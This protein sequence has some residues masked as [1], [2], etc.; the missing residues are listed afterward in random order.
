[1]N[2]VTQA[3]KTAFEC[4]SEVDPRIATFIQDEL[5]SQRTSLKLIASENYSPLAVQMAMG[6][7]LTDKYAE[8]FPGHRFYS[9][10][11]N[12]DNIEALAVQH[13]KDLF[14]AEHAYVQ[15][16]S[17]ADAN[18]IAFWSILR[19]RVQLPMLERTGAD[20]MGMSREEWNELRRELN[21]QRMMAMNLDSGGH[22]THGFRRN[23]S[24]QLFDCHLYGVSPKTGLLDY[25]DIAKQME[26]VK[27]LIFLAGYSSYPRKIDFERLREICD[28]NGAIFMVD[29]AHF[30]GLVAGKVFDG[31]YNPVPY[32][33]VVTTT[34][35]KTLRGP[36]GGMILCKKEFAES[37]DKGCPMVMGG[38]MPHVM[39]SKAVAFAVAK[40]PEFR[41]YAQAIVDNAQTMAEGF[42]KRDITVMTGGTDNHLVLLDVR[43]TNLNGRQAENALLEARIS[44]NRN[45]L[46]PKDP[47]GAW[48][49]SGLRLGTPAITTLG[50]GE[51]EVDEIADIISKVL[52][53][54]SPGEKKNLFVL[55][56]DVKKEAGEK[57]VALLKNFPLYP[58]LEI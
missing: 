5:Q 34:T 22:L 14:G 53:E 55:P 15:P 27:P 8:G 3:F 32:A 33:D 29:M 54:T 47:N 2:P 45:V 21:G 10:C 25:D 28:R 41:D 42:K 30:S 26:E 1:M 40:T 9:G 20:E 19:T 16:H 13:A 4:I 35:H 7:W 44:V 24:S 23:I 49:T 43:N 18:L 50:M 11:E 46:P 6:N 48:Y 31:P 52:K 38:P 57:V 12:V 56:E 17:G 36:R 39:A 51:K 58:E 37:V